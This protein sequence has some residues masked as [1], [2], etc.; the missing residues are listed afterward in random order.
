MNDVRIGVAGRKSLV[1]KGKRPR[2]KR[3]AR[4]RGTFSQKNPFQPLT[5]PGCRVYS[6]CVD[7][8]INTE[9]TRG[10]RRLWR[11]FIR[12]LTIREAPFKAKSGI[13]IICLSAD[14]GLA[15]RRTMK[16]V[17]VNDSKE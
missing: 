8:V 12:S 1:S 15:D 9:P 11:R 2:E 5:I 7:A 10:S 4:P 13:V 16:I 6:E 3:D 17:L 14:H